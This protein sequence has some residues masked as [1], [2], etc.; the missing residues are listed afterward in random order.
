MTCFFMDRFESRMNPGFL[1]ESENGILR[2][3]GVT[4]SG[5]ETVEGFEEDEK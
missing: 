2:E 3:T 4:E 1:A 5:R